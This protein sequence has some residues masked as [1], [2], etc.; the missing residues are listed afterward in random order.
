MNLF[1]HQP[2]LADDLL[3]VWEERS[4]SRFDRWADLV[5]ILGELDQ[6]GRRRQA[7]ESK[8]WIERAVEQAVADFT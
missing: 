6:F 3:K 2:H 8:F 1:Q 4:G 7:N 5:S